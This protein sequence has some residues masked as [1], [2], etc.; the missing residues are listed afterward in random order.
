MEKSCINDILPAPCAA[1]DKNSSINSEEEC[2]ECNELDYPHC[3]NQNHHQQ[4]QN[5]ITS[6]YNYLQNE[7]LF[8]NYQTLFPN[9]EQN[10]HL[11]QHQL[12]N[13]HN[14]FSSIMSSQ[15]IN[16]NCNL[17]NHNYIQQFTNIH[18]FSSY[19]VLGFYHEPQNNI[20][21]I[22]EVPNEQTYYEDINS[23]TE[24]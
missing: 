23:L 14:L 24:N 4:Y 3:G 20:E 15:F 7:M 21:T 12:Y 19:E 17:F 22:G 16:T 8:R 1:G 2:N 9:Y 5:F 18:F 10:S 6:K 11:F 13:Q